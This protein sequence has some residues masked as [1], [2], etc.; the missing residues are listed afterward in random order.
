MLVKFAKK[1]EMKKINITSAFIISSILIWGCGGNQQDSKL[2]EAYEYHKT[3]IEIRER[4]GEKFKTLEPDSPDLELWKERLQEWDNNFVEVP[5][6]GH[7]HHHDENE[8]HDHHHHHNP[9]P[10]LSS[11][12]HLNLQK[13]LLEEVKEIEKA[14]T[15]D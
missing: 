8:H 14:L 12:E 13:G 11:S 9:A 5:G 1:T 3:S 7:E 6:F 4:I 2:E 10:N 15:M